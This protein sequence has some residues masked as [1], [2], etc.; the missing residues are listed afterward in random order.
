MKW[1]NWKKVVIVGVLGSLLA[2]CAVKPGAAPAQSDSGTPVKG[3]T[4]RVAMQNDVDGLDPQRTVSASTFSVTNNIFDTLVGTDPK[5]NLVPRLASKWSASPDAKSWTFELR[6]DVQFHNG[7]KMT[8]DDVE[9]SFKRLLEKESPRAKDYSMIEQ[10]NVDS[11][12]KVTFKLKAPYAPF[13]S[14]LAMPWTAIVAKESVDQLKTKPVGTGPFVLQEWTPQ[15]KVVLERNKNYY[16]KDQ[17]Y[18]DSAEFRVMPDTAAQMINLKSGQI[19]VASISGEQA[20]EVKSDSQLKLYA[21]P[22]NAVQVLAMNN[23]VAPLNDVRVRQAINLA[24]SKDTV[25]QGSNW[26]FGDKI[27]SHMSPVDPSYKDLNNVSKNDIAKAKQLLQEAGYG[28]GFDI[29]LSLPQP[30]TMHVKA[31]EIVA[32]QLKQI[33]IRVKLETVDWGKWLKEIYSGRNYQMTIIS[34]TGRLDPDAML[35][36]YA[37]DNK[38]NYMNYKNPA[39]DEALKKGIATADKAERQKIYAEIQEQLAKDVPAVYLQAPHTLLALN[40]KVQGFD[41]YPIDIYELKNVYMAK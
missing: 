13:V 19:D 23:K 29:T 5:G 2:G 25:I 35:N 11:P 34:H 18:L 24:I 20:E 32:D 21:K 9:F 39:V 26:G 7:R 6:D 22:S 40:K 12:T 31:G 4:L 8:A 41:S 33:G 27:G 17:P 38:E 16:L 3:G 36:R 28:Q 14:S 30:Y 10:I 37:S 15:Q 1:M